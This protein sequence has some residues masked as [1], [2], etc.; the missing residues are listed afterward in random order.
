MFHPNCL[1]YIHTSSSACLIILAL[2][3]AQAYA[4]TQ[5]H[6]HTHVH[7]DVCVNNKVLILKVLPTCCHPSNTLTDRHTALVRPFHS[8]PLF[9]FFF[10]LS[11]S[12]LS[13]KYVSDLAFPATT[14]IGFIQNSCR[15]VLH[16][17][18]RTHAHT[19]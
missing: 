17:H 19:P 7:N 4:R 6:T 5:T 9:F 11:L 14:F 10:F 2:K 18:A 1:T 13:L 12:L 15:L 8:F 3:E 16:R